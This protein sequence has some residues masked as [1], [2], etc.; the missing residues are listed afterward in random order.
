S[1]VAIDPPDSPSLR[2]SLSPPAPTRRQLP[3]EPRQEAPGKSLR[4]ATCGRAA[5]FIRRGPETGQLAQRRAE[6]LDAVAGFLEQGL[7]SGV[8]NAEIRPEAECRAM[9]HRDALLLE[10]AGDEILVGFDH[11]SGRQLAAD[12]PGT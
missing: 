5:Q 10:Q 8:G 9:H 7:G 2:P 6:A 1:R 3:I 4:G 12:Q 11:L